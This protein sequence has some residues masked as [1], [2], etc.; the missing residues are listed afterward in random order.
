MNAPRLAGVDS[1][2][3]ARQLS[4]FKQRVRGNH[5]DDFYGAQMSL[6]AQ[7]LQSEQDITDVVAYINSLQP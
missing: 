4:Y 6:I 5:P 2:Y 1:W 7:S 3:L